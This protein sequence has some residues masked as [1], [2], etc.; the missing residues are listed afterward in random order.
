M[1]NQLAVQ[2]QMCSGGAWGRIMGEGG[3]FSKTWAYNPTHKDIVVCDV[4]SNPVSQ[5]KTDGIKSSEIWW[6][7]ANIKI[8]L[9]IK[10]T[11]VYYRLHEVLSLSMWSHIPVFIQLCIILTLFICFALKSVGCSINSNF[12]LRWAHLKAR[13]D[14]RDLRSSSLVDTSI[15]SHPKPFHLFSKASSKSSSSI[16]KCR[17]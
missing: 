1:P 17:K 16:R 5:E 15:L 8:C 13:C 6:M 9:W 11:R 4:E 2:L 12:I 3:S 14:M 7:G 10:E